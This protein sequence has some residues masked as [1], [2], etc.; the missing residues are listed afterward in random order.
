[1]VTTRVKV[2]PHHSEL[3]E[4][5]DLG[6]KTVRGRKEQFFPREL[7]KLYTR[8]SELASGKPARKRAQSRPWARR[9]QAG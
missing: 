2:P 4:A 1:M 3:D 6:I 7:P 5:V 9:N 8:K